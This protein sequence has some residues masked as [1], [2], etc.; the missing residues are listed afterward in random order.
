MHK[1][2]IISL[3]CAKNQVDA[4]VMLGLLHKHGYKIVNQSDDADIIIVNTCGFIGPA[5]EESIQAILEQAK[6][7]RQGNCKALIITGCLGQ[8]YSKEL[9][10]EIPE[11]DV[12]VGTGNY[13]RIVDI[14]EELNEGSSRDNY[15]GNLSAQLDDGLPRMLS[16]TGSTAYLKI[17]EG[18]DNCCTYCI[19]PKLRGRF[20]S[21]SVTGLIDEAKSLVQ[22]GIKEL[23]IIAQDISRYGQ[24]TDGKYNLVTLL[25]ELCSIHGLEWIRLMYCYPD[26]VTD[27]LIDLIASEAKICNYLD[28]PLQH[29]NQNILKRMNR[30]IDGFHI[31]NL[32]DTIRKRIP[33]I[34]LRTSLIVG[35]PGEGESEYKELV[36][37]VKE[38][39]FQH[40][41]VFAY[42]RE[43][44]TPAASFPN[45]VEEAVKKERR[46]QLMAIQ[47]KTSRRLLRRRQTQVCKVLVEGI[48]SD[49]IYYGRSYGE[50]PEVDGLVY[51]SSDNPLK[52][53]EF[54][55][56][57]I[58][59]AFEYDLLGE[60]YESRK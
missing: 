47:S 29:I 7:K 57:R 14:L 37:F 53:G 35:F 18:C 56:V 59:R 16:T 20:R 23:V 33:D 3:G 10:A 32:L 39:Y 5:K 28:I 2:G 55:D 21:R 40:I 19:I 48:E 44:N 15:L 45:Q 12:I 49:G 31:R 13:S 41:G 11:I 6:Y 25:R 1:I 34:V 54:T 17:A 46:S 60:A 51:I 22:T 38:G 4:E 52:I 50:A 27:E 43:E 8:R 42:S 36:D 24:D 30:K 58:T 26:R 9:L